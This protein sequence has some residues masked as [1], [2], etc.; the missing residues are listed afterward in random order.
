M[1]RVLVTGGSGFLGRRLVKKLLD[2]YQNLEVITI[3]RNGEGIVKLMTLCA[4]NRLKPLVGD[5]RNEEVLSFAMR[6]VDTVVHLAA[7]KYINLCEMCPAEAI[8]TNVQATAELLRLFQGNT[9][10]S[11]STDKAVEPSSCYGAT[12]L[13][14][15]KLTLAEAEKNKGKRFMVVR[16]GNIFGSSGSVL[17]N[18]WRQIRRNN[19]IIVSDPDMTRFFI[20]VETLA[21]FIITVL[22]KGKSGHIYIPSQEVIRLGDLA[23]AFIELYG[24]EKSRTKVVGRFQGE[25]QHEK[26]FLPGEKVISEMK[27]TSSEQGTRLS[28][29]QIKDWLRRHAASREY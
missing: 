28:P 22:E 16:S 14:V 6:E 8:T 24:D 26:L 17:E 23:K 1:N 10:I 9:F 21:E 5:I 3:A 29:A 27:Y 20:D 15:E 4:T 7:M 19:E 2:K 12:K 18:W 13:I 25:K 11:M